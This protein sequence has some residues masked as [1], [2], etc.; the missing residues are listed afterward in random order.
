MSELL[1]FIFTHEDAFKSRGRLASLYSDFRIQQATNPDGYH[2]NILAWR[3]ALAHATR[4]GLVPS[5]TGAN[6][7]LILGTGEALLRELA[8]KDFGRPLALAAVIHD[9]A[10]SKEMIP[11]KDFLA[12][13]TSIY[14]RSWNLNPFSVLSW[15][16][17][18]LG[19]IGGTTSQDKLAVGEFVVMANLEAASS[20][21]IA[22]ASSHKSVVDRVYSLDSFRAAFAHALSPSRE[23]TPT[24]IA[25]LLTHLSRDKSALSY[26]PAS[27]TIKFAPANATPSPITQQDITIAHLRGLIAS[28]NEQIPALDARIAACDAAARSAVA[29]KTPA[30]RTTAL[31]ALRSK[32]LAEQGLQRR[33]DTLAQL[34]AVYAKIEA[35]ADNVEVVRAMEASAGVLRGLHAQVGG[36]EGVEAVVEALRE[37]MGK[38]DEVNDVINDVGREGAAVDEDEVDEE[39]AALERAEKEKREMEEAERTAAR[40]REVERLEE[41]RKRVEK[42]REEEKRRAEEARSSQEEEEAQVLETSRELKRM[43]LDENR[44]V[45][46]E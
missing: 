46:A 41:D 2:A 36:T 15:G 30:A 14:S 28:L 20:A 16:L 45:P 1:E 35:A 4:A 37:E 39:F 22:Q 27:Q 11:L 10:T 7:L 44:P 34:E 23:F 33:A 29:T 17:Q 8:S 40:L 12:A 13:K 38:A 31:A 26:D 19:V 25:V 43:S 18:Q 24:D 21:V 6:N 5:Q 9:A 42:E 3:Q 32:K